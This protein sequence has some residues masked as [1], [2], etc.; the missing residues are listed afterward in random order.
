ME[1][2][3]YFRNVPKTE[4]L[5]NY[6]DKKLA[7][8]DRHSLKIL[9]AKLEVAH[10]KAKDPEERYVLQLTLNSNG[11]LLRAEEKGSDLFAA[12]DKLVEVIDRQIERYKTRA[13]EKHRKS[14]PSE[15]ELPMETAEDEVSGKVVKVKKFSVK[16]MSPEE[17]IEQMELL[18]HNFFMFFNPELE[19]YNIVYRRRDDDYGLIIPVI[20]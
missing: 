9:E 17:A 2:Q 4:A 8:I 5:E 16:P 13:S 1:F 6:I 15:R 20:G 3:L 12:I 19:I 11:T 14:A 10:K 18:G 7:K